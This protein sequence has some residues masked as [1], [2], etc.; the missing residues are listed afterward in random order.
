MQI[1]KVALLIIIAGFLTA[2]GGF[3]VMDNEVDDTSAAQSMNSFKV[4]AIDPRWPDRPFILEVPVTAYF[5][6]RTLEAHFAGGVVPRDE[7]GN[8][9]IGIPTG[10]IERVSP[11][12]EHRWSFRFIPSDLSFG[13]MTTEVCDANFDYVQQNL[14]A[15]LAGVGFCPWGFKTWVQEISFR[16][17]PIYIR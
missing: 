3:K 16:G 13:D 8:P 15:I 12:S 14:N 11:N 10:D 5:N 6:N 9:D 4:T 17:R 1:S 2:C 7:E